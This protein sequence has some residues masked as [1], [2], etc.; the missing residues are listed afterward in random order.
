MP[1][2]EMLRA[3]CAP[4]RRAEWLVRDAEIWTPA[5]A[6]HDGY[7]SKEVWP[8]IDNPDEVVIIVRWES[9]A[10]W[11]SFPDELNRARRQ[12]AGRA[13]VDHE[14]GA[15]DLWRVTWRARWLIVT[16]A[17]QGIGAACA[18]ALAQ[19][20]ATVV[21]ADLDGEAAQQTAAAIADA[22]GVRGHRADRRW[23]TRC[24][25]TR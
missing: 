5:L 24:S 3:R 23:P 22:T 25:V 21:V 4:D 8:S 12:N 14:R 20:G 16:G 13:G 18:L 7:I 11:R 19:A 6:A 10:Q 17:A 2:I 1:V 9:L 15:G